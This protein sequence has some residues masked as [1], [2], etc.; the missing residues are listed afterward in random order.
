MTVEEARKSAMCKLLMIS[1]AWTMQITNMYTYHK[2]G[3]KNFMN[4]NNV[5]AKFT[6]NDQGYDIANGRCCIVGEAHK[7]NDTSCLVCHG[8][9]YCHFFHSESWEKFFNNIEK[10][11]DH[12]I[13]EHQ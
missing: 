4:W 11:C 7:M 8:F 6:V 12:F 10:F 1:P 3:Y 13:E 2:N 9:A 5:D